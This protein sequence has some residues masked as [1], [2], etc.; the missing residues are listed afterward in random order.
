M[1]VGAKP[2][3]KAKRKQNVAKRQFQGANL[4]QLNEGV[5]ELGFGCTNA[6]WKALTS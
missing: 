3:G 1:F 6:C 2:P 4:T 5:L